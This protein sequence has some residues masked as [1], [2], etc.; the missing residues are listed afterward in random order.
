MA[1]KFVSVS[2][3]SSP[4]DIMEAIASLISAVKAAKASGLSGVALIGADVSAAVAALAPLLPEIGSVQ[5]DLLDDHLA[6]YSGC[7]LGLM[8][9]VKSVLS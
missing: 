2:V 9:V 7:S 8:D 3:E 4:Y 5:A 1:K 6:F